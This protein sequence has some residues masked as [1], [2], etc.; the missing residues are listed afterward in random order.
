MSS[1]DIV[2]KISAIDSCASANVVINHTIV[3]KRNTFGKPVERDV[4]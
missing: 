2:P 4:A 3:T 1:L